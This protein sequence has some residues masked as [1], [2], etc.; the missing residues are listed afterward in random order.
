[1]RSDMILILRERRRLMMTLEHVE[2]RRE[3]QVRAIAGGARVREHLNSLGI[4]VGDRIVV[5]ERA[6]F[7]GPLIVEI[8]GSRVALGRGIARKVRVEAHE[9]RPGGTAELG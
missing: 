8:H 6:P 7:R 2:T 3:A 1:M 5:M 9:I 4:H